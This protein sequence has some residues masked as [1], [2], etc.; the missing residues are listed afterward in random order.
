[1]RSF[2]FA[3][4]LLAVGLAAVASAA[5]VVTTGGTQLGC[6]SPTSSTSDAKPV[7]TD[8]TNNVILPS[9][10][11]VATKAEALK[12]STAALA[13][14]PSE[15]T[16]A[17]AQSAWRETKGAW[18]KTE[19]FRFGPVETKSISGAIDYWPGRPS[20][21]EQ[22]LASDQPVTVATVDALGSLAKG[23]VALEY[24]LFDDV[25]GNAAILSKLTGEGGARRLQYAA[26]VAEILDG[27]TR[28]LLAAWS[29][30]GENFAKELIDAGGAGALFPSGKAAVD[31][32]VNSATFAAELV[33]NTKIGKPFGKKTGG[34]PAPD[35]EES[36]LSDNSIADMVA[37]LDGVI[38]VYTGAH[39]GVDGMGISDLVRA[40]NASLDDRVV[41]GLADARAKI[42][43]IPP[44]FRTA[45][46]AAPAAVETAYQSVR[47]VK[48]TM[49]TEVAGALGTTLKFNDN[50]G[51]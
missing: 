18:R 25:G 1:M 49:T 3:T 14:A 6:S 33:T 19:A 38:A 37:T 41:A 28:E 2:R 45:V 30:S 11:D 24:L 32:L 40:K 23:F 47:D 4:T 12:G 51:D 21:I 48:N 26:A 39:G 22:M 9:Y 5:V 46:T 31:Q 43:A 15:S 27:K 13:A 8:L 42:L 16:L 35:Q 20:T 50:D 10:Q 7:L 44:P 34:T 29:P 36:P 17:A